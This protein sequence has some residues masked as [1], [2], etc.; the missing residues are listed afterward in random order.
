MEQQ[1][2]HSGASVLERG[3]CWVEID[4][5]VAFLREVDAAAHA[6]GTRHVDLEIDGGVAFLREASGDAQGEVGAQQGL[7]ERQAQR[8][9]SLP[10]DFLAP[11]AEC[12][13]KRQ[14]FRE[15]L[16]AENPE[17][18]DAYC[19]HTP[20]PSI[21][22]SS[23]RLYL[24]LHKLWHDEFRRTY[25]PKPI[26][27]SAESGAGLPESL[28]PGIYEHRCFKD[29]EGRVNGIC[30]RNYRSV[31][32]CTKGSDCFFCHHE[33]HFLNC[34]RAPIRRGSKLGPRSSEQL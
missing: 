13:A 17:A 28:P 34:D 11:S 18:W 25:P 6:T 27:S 20:P 22:H 24:R 29:S 4:R 33:D 3:P 9:V 8:N 10:V 14:K 5:G 12:V 21:E 1:A 26:M 23:T 7:A 30:R 15:I 19:T 16:R 2:R 32:S 31:Q